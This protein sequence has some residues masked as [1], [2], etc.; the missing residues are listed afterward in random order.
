MKYGAIKFPK[1][2]YCRIYS[3]LTEETVEAVPLYTCTW[4][5]H[6]SNLHKVN[7]PNSGYSCSSP[8]L[9]RQM[10]GQTVPVGLLLSRKNIVIP[11]GSQKQVSEGEKELTAVRFLLS[12]RVLQNSFYTLSGVVWGQRGWEI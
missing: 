9:S 1:I 5:V 6:S 12:Y 3:E 4:E 11:K 8:I 10:T 7:S 2:Q